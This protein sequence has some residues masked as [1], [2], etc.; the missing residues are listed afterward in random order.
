M[1]RASGK[2]SEAHIYL[3]IREQKNYRR[4]NLEEQE[5]TVSWTPETCIK[6]G[7]SEM[8]GN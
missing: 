8:E 1:Q 5:K 4:N 2:Y 7:G 6:K 3:E